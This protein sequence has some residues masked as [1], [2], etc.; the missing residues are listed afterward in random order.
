MCVETFF[1]YRCITGFNAYTRVG[2]YVDMRVDMFTTRVA[3]RSVMG[4]AGRRV[5]RSST[6]ARRESSTRARRARIAA[7]RDAS[8]A[9]SRALEPGRTGRGRRDRDSTRGARDDGATRARFATARDKMTANDRR[10]CRRARA[11]FATALTVCACA[12]AMARV[13]RGDETPV[14]HILETYNDDNDDT[15][16]DAHE[17]SE[18]FERFAARTS[19]AGAGADSHAGHAHASAGHAHASAEETLTNVSSADV[20]TTYAGAD[21]KLNE[22]E[23]LSALSLAARCLSESTCTFIASEAESAAA[24]T[25]GLK[26]FKLKMG[27]MVA[28]FFEGLAGGMLP[29]LFVRTLPKM[30]SALEFMNAFSGGLFLASGF[31]HLVPHALESATEARIGTAKEYPFAMVMVMLGFLIAF[32]VERVVFHTHSHVTESEGDGEHGHGHG[33][34]HGQSKKHHVDSS[35]VVVVDKASTDAC[36]TCAHDEK[37]RRVSIFAQTRTALLFMAGVALHASLAGV[38]LGLQ[39][40]RNSVYAIF[41]AIASH[42]AAAAFSIG[43]AFLRCGMTNPQTLFIF[44][45]VF[46]F[47]T[48]IGILIGCAAESADPAVSAV[49]EGIAAGTFIYVG[50]VEVIGDEFETQ[51]Q[52]C[53]DEHGHDHKLAPHTHTVHEAPARGVRIY[54]FV[55][56]TA[57]V[58]VIALAQLGVEHAH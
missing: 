50:T 38:S 20:I 55:C 52:S 2:K 46:S 24:A 5:R 26:H 36:D 22:T 30:Q 6:R 15:K 4:F 54:K 42:K 27:L 32:F 34:G 18:L 33:H 16:M 29:S 58:L 10:R 19:G 47:I 49:L 17:L 48:P 43:C 57:G 40:D 13:A 14:D 23:L 1:V 9:R 37:G 25:G 41:T 51:T 53:E 39:S 8:S 21:Q 11:R 35:V 45:T 28:V 12:C 44:M 31:V 7:L 3:T 56:Y